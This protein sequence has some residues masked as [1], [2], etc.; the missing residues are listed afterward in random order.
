M[1][2]APL[3]P[4][5]AKRRALP[6]FEVRRDVHGFADG[7][8]RGGW[9][10]LRLVE[11]ATINEDHVEEIVA[12]LNAAPLDWPVP[13]NG[14][15]RRVAGGGKMNSSAVVAVGFLFVGIANV[16]MMTEWHSGLVILVAGMLVGAH[17]VLAVQHKEPRP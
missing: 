14:R 10:L 16:A 9:T 6:P 17:A 3:P 5:P 1:T 13:H 11:G 8:Q 4:K 2:P 12:R 15:K 7:I